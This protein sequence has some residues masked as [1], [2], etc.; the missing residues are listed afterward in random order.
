MI[1][2]E[3]L[4]KH[5]IFSEDNPQL[6]EEPFPRKYLGTK[7]IIQYEEKKKISYHVNLVLQ[8]DLCGYLYCEHTTDNFL[9]ALK[10]N[11][12]EEPYYLAKN[13]WERQH[14]FGYDEKIIKKL[15]KNSTFKIIE[16]IGTDSIKNK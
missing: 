15:T 5:I 3:E 1:T 12:M 13:M 16:I 2:Q 4:D 11:N 9:E 10:F 8:K 14:I 6:F 7:W